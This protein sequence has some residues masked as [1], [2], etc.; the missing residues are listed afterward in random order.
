MGNTKQIMK[1]C[2]ISQYFRKIPLKVMQ[3]LKMTFSEISQIIIIIIIIFSL[4]ERA[5][6]QRDLPL[7]ISPTVSSLV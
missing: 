7:S 2:E 1:F 3:D 4:L 6:L 5:S